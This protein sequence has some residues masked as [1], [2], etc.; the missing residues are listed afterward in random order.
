M[1]NLC[2]PVLLQFLQFE[3]EVNGTPFSS[4][5]GMA[6]FIRVV[7]TLQGDPLTEGQS[8]LIT[9]FMQGTFNQNPPITNS[10]HRTWDI[11]II[12]D[13]LLTLGENEAMLI[14]TLAGKAILL[15]LLT[16]MCRL[17]D[18]AQLQMSLMQVHQK[19][20]VFT[21][22]K[23]TKTFTM[24]SHIA[25]RNLQ[26]LTLKKF[27]ANPALCP[28]TTLAAYIDRTKSFRLGLDKVFVLASP[29]PTPAKFATLS[30]WAKCLMKEAGLGNFTIH[31]T[32][33]STATCA[34]LMGMP[35]NQIVRNVGWV[36]ENTF[37]KRY[38]KP[39]QKLDPIQVKTTYSK[40]QAE[41]ARKGSSQPQLHPTLQDK[42]NFATVWQ[43]QE[44]RS[45]PP[46]SNVESST[47]KFKNK[48]MSCKIGQVTRKKLQKSSTLDG[49]A[50]RPVAPQKVIIKTLQTKGKPVKSKKP[51]EHRL[52]TSV[53]SL[54]QNKNMEKQ[55]FPKFITTDDDIVN[56]VTANSQN[57][58][59]LSDSVTGPSSKNVHSSRNK[60]R[61]TEGDVTQQCTTSPSLITC[62][63]QVPVLRM[64]AL[65]TAT[66]DPSPC[67]SV[68]PQWIRPVTW[69]HNLHNTGTTQATD[70]QTNLQTFMPSNAVSTSVWADSPLNLCINDQQA[71]LQTV[72]VDTNDMATG[73][74]DNTPTPE[75][76]VFSDSFLADLANLDV[77]EINK[78][79][80]TME[81]DTAR[82][83]RVASQSTIA[84]LRQHLARNSEK[85]ETL[86]GRQI[87]KMLNKLPDKKG[88]GITS[89]VRQ[90]I[91]DK[92]LRN[93]KNDSILE[94]SQPAP[95]SLVQIENMGL[96]TPKKSYTKLF[97]HGRLTYDARVA[98]LKD[99]NKLSEEETK[100]ITS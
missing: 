12:L 41:L 16:T 13:F 30:R 17:N 22:A 20:T 11:N 47:R 60:S 95:A 82:D 18:V 100:T 21:L 25:Q 86:G 8:D 72:T 40:E 83:P 34:L 92:I 84:K 79:L 66:R 51:Q 43:T 64:G 44:P 67:T 5:R 37:I 33:G 4:L 6:Q 88:V 49:F 52:L 38:M 23:P 90:A 29:I 54:S 73:Q 55:V 14:N 28:T 74:G 39:L 36:S 81:N 58:P 78:Y 48:S 32:R 99:A 98:L 63:P 2:F 10:R 94:N 26:K 80:S 96:E 19:E 69:P 76:S 61:A 42:F 1:T 24:K 50:Q 97:S 57:L 62:G 75:N 53:N 3:H 85:W 56:S 46:S 9:K 77:E 35:V 45:F 31:S 27:S 15:I 68:G 87:S 91:K 59:D 65:R 70:P 7:R 71:T 89:E 93:S